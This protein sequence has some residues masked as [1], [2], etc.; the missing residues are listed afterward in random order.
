MIQCLW[1]RFRQDYAEQITDYINGIDE[2][3]QHADKNNQRR[4]VK[5]IEYL[6]YIA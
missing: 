6:Q 1:G 4:F 2:P 3:A 5:D